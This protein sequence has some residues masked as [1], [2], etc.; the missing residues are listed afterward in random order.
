MLTSKKQ[1]VNES[2]TDII[3]QSTGLQIEISFDKQKLVFMLILSLMRHK[4][5]N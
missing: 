5:T 1:T 4:Y 3:Q 2:Y